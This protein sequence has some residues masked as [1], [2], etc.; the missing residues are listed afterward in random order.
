MANI[1]LVNQLE[2]YRSLLAPPQEH[3]GIAYLASYLR[4]E[5]HKVF[6]VDGVAAELPD[7]EVWEAIAPMVQDSLLCFTAMGYE[8]LHSARALLNRA[9]A[10]ALLPKLVVLGGSFM[11]FGV[12]DAL[13]LFPNAAAVVGEGE[14]ALAALAKAIDEQ[15]DWRH[16]PSIA[17]KR[18]AQ[19]LRTPPAP[20]IDPD[21][22]PHPDRSPLQQITAIRA[23]AGLG[24]SA[25]MQTTRGCYARCKFCAS[26]MAVEGLQRGYRVRSARNVFEEICALGDEYGI[27]TISF[28]D[29][30]FLGRAQRLKKRAYELA[31]LIEQSGRKIQFDLYCRP[32][33]F[34]APVLAR[35]REVGLSSIFVGFE[36]FYSPTLEL[37]G[38][39]ETPERYVEILREC[40][41]NGLPL[42]PGL[43]MV[44]PFSTIDEVLVNIETL[45]EFSEMLAARALLGPLLMG[46]LMLFEGTPLVYLCQKANIP[47][48][49]NEST[50]NT[51]DYPID[52]NVWMYRTVMV[53]LRKK[54]LETPHSSRVIAQFR[55]GNVDAKTRASVGSTLFDLATRVAKTSAALKPE[56]V[57]ELPAIARA[58]S[59]ELDTRMQ[60]LLEA[61][62]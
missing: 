31:D 23:R 33:E 51:Y 4:R 58:F 32:D 14:P 48:R 44:H 50:K 40:A 5:G 61:S 20:F 28:I 8:W 39:P 7:Q 21:E 41:E 42:T 56:E 53:A 19:T 38:R 57:R 26:S 35:L 13:A 15:K 54:S 34:D 43:I 16:A 59:R 17:Y 36:S 9:E 6:M 18:E 37:F 49:R 25:A 46:E 27:D 55:S 3:L 1:I 60:S 22:L 2:G 29:E 11:D 12:E 24:P 52:P 10:Q 47:L 30:I 45:S 62:P